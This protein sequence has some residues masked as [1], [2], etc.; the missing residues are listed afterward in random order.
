MKKLSTLGMIIGASLALFLSPCIGR[1]QRH[2][3]YP[4]TVRKLESDGPSRR[5]ASRA[6]TGERIGAELTALTLMAGTTATITAATTAT[7][8]HTM[9]TA[10]TIVRT[11]RM[12]VTI[13][14]ATSGLIHSDN[15]QIVRSSSSSRHESRS[16]CERTSRPP[17]A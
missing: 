14:R 7:I 5:S 8:V 11:R 6:S 15:S 1:Q 13:V 4:S 10:A 2:H 9:L 3:T 16:C 17:S 12:A